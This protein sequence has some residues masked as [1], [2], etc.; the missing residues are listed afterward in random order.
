M[1]ELTFKNEKEMLEHSAVQDL[2][3]SKLDEAKTELEQDYY[4]KVKALKD[5]IV[6]QI[7]TL[8]IET[9]SFYASALKDAI[10]GG[11]DEEIKSVHQAT[12]DRFSKRSIESLS[13][14]LVDI[15]DEY[16]RKLKDSDGVNKTMQDALNREPGDDADNTQ[17]TDDTTNGNSDT[18]T[19]AD[20][21]TPNDTQTDTDQDGDGN[22]DQDQDNQS[23]EP[24]DDVNN[25][26]G[27]DSQDVDA[28]A[29]ASKDSPFSRV[30]R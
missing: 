2:I 17:D 15:N 11:K 24:T 7:I 1:S 3:D 25:P 13:D 5:M 27:G 14:M 12:R 23:Q 26:N 18:D 16:M 29:D 9:D 21:A 8:G 20:T 6:D 22:G 10:E 28:N 19:N 4:D 30:L